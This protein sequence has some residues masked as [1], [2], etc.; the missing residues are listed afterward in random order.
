MTEE[1]ILAK[2]KALT[3]VAHGHDDGARDAF[4]AMAAVEKAA[5]AGGNLAERLGLALI[6]A[7]M[8][9]GSEDLGVAWEIVQAVLRDLSA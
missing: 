1:W 4:L 8:D 3:A 7:Q 5:K 2:E 6:I 9:A